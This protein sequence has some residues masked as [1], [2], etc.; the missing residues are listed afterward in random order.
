MKNKIKVIIAILVVFS[1][2]LSASSQ[3]HATTIKVQ[4]MDMATALMKNDF[5]TFSK[6]MHPN[7]IA[8]AGGK[9]NMK[10][11]MDSAYAAMKL[12]GVTFKKYWIGSPG[13][14][15]DYKNQLQAVLPESTV[16]KTPL[17][18]LTAETSMIV[19]STDKG[20]LYIRRN[21]GLSRWEY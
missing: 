5:T 6:Y 20:K 15:V 12:F 13:E 19:I 1:I 9:E 17:G 21:S 18:E 10:S 16:I 4:A 7:I 2:S 8:F 14:I 11:K 3:N